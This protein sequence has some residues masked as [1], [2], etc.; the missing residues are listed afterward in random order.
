MDSLCKIRSFNTAL[1]I[2]GQHASYKGLVTDYWKWWINQFLFTS[3]SAVQIYVFHIFTADYTFSLLNKQ[4][5]SA[6]T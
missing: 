6:L 2:R 1:G 4:P 5:N 3:L